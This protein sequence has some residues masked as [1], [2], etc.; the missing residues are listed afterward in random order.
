MKLGKKRHA[1]SEQE[2]FALM[3][4]MYSDEDKNFSREQHRLELTQLRADIAKTEAETAEVA[5][6]SATA[7]PGGRQGNLEGKVCRPNLT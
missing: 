7:D 4:I 2:R 5:N 6:K 3:R 1:A